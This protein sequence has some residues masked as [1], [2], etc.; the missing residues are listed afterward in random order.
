MK[1]DGEEVAA[2][3]APKTAATTAASPP[4]LE[5]Q[6]SLANATLE[7]RAVAVMMFNTAKLCAS[8]GKINYAIMLLVQVSATDG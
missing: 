8:N 7:P 2:D 3:E 5:L 1:S 6:M 4:P